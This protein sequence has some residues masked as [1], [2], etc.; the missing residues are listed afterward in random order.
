[1][2]GTEH[3]PKMISMDIT[4]SVIVEDSKWHP[5]S[6][7][8]PY[9]KKGLLGKCSTGSFKTT[10]PPTLADIKKWATSTWKRTFGSPST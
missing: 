10:E 1:M 8:E 6:E 5:Q 4:F 2:H 3:L 9:D 7:E